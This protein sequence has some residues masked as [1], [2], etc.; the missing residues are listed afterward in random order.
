DLCD[1][2]EIRNFYR[3]TSSEE[4]E[5]TYSI[6][7]NY[8]LPATFKG[9]AGDDT[10]QLTARVDSTSDASVTYEMFRSENGEVTKCGTGET[11]VTSSANI[12]QTVGING[13][14][15][16]DCGFTEASAGGSIIFK[17]NLKAQKDAN[18]YVST[19]NF[20]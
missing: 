1:A 18:A 12:W 8:Q 15:A 6:F 3:W 19:L 10:V 20:I 4:S 2:G 5:Q 9:F 16:T 17:I 13:D 11:E 14:E 7:I